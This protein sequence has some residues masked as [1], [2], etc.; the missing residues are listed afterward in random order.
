MRR[1]DIELLAPAGSWAGLSA[2]LRAGADAVYFGVGALNM[3]SASAANF[4][5]ADMRKLVTMAHGGG[6]RAYLAMNVTLFDDEL[7]EMRASLYEAAEAGVDAAIVS[8]QAAIAYAASLGLPLHLSTQLS[9]SNL[10]SLRFYARWA[11]VAVLARELSLERI[12]AIDEGIERDGIRGPSGQPVRIELFV[13]GAFCMATSGSCYLSL[14]QYGSAAN[15][16]ACLQPCRRRYRLSDLETGEE[17]AVDNEYL[18]S[19]K[20]LKTI[21]F[22]D[23]IVAAG[24]RVLKIEGRARPPEYVDATVRCY[25]EALEALED[26]SYGPE[27]VADWDRRLAAVFNRGFWDGHYLGRRQSELSGR[28]GSAAAK[29]R[30]YAGFCSNWYAARGVASFMIEDTAVAPGD[31]LLVVGPTT[32]AL[33]ARPDEIWLDGAPVREAGR[34]SEPSFALTRKVRRGDKLYKLIPTT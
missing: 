22:L 1:S 28:Y 7:D 31:E 15:R 4:K 9:I 29:R 13:H 23:R 33:E 19:P 6:V 25:S 21:H 34:G 8:D 26:G 2:A 17:L 16:G 32:G 14:H 27:R 5:R 30:A 20:D 12:A 24:A 11:D 10:E 3:R 18:L